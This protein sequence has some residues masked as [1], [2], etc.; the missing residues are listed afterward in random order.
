LICGS[1]VF[2][3]NDPTRTAPQDNVAAPINIGPVNQNKA[4][5]ISIGAGL[6]YWISKDGDS[7]ALKNDN[8]IIQLIMGQDGNVGI[9]TTTPGA[10]L[11]VNGQIKIAGGSPGAGKVLTSDASGL[12]TW[13]TPTG[14]GLPSGTAG[15][16]LAP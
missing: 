15:Q 10:K 2:A 5:D 9:G 13:Q 11:D 4:G 16:T 7:F 12:A 3:W 1:I 14:G 6:R 8:S